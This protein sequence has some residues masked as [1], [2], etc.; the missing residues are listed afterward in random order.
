MI[1][2]YRVATVDDDDDGDDGYVCWAIL[3]DA[4][5]HADGDAYAGNAADVT[6]SMVA[7]VDLDG[8]DDDES[9]DDEMLPNYF[10]ASLD[11]AVFDY[12]CLRSVLFVDSMADARYL[13]VTDGNDAALDL[14]VVP[15]SINAL[16][17]LV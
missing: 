4:R 3:A 13:F 9:Y 11:Y 14:K 7:V 17:Y 6:D 1:Y 5:A 10:E 15:Y 8:Y 2:P 16:N 12:Y